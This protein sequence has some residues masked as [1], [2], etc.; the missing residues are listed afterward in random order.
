[1]PSNAEPAR[2]ASELH[3]RALLRLRAATE[4]KDGRCF[5]IAMVLDQYTRECLCI[6]PD[7]SRTGEKSVKDMK[8]LIGVRSAPESIT[9]DSGTEFGGKTSYVRRTKRKY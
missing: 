6:H 7:R 4:S 3:T 5:R 9:S 2:S 1:M 8:R